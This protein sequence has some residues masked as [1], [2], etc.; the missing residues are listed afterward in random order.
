MGGNSHR[1]NKGLKKSFKYML[2]AEVRSETIIIGDSLLFDHQTGVGTNQHTQEV[3]NERFFNVD[4]TTKKVRIFRI[5]RCLCALFC[6]VDIKK[7]PRSFLTSC[8]CSI[9]FLDLQALVSVFDFFFG[10]GTVTVP[11]RVHFYSGLA[12]RP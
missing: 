11:N 8:A 4:K 12:R 5:I 7:K 1:D 2:L 3:K 10:V 9:R 6:F